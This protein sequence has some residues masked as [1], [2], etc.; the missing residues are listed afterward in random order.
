MIHFRAHH[1]GEKPSGMSGRATSFHNLRRG[2]GFDLR[3]FEEKIR[4]FR[5]QTEKQ[6]KKIRRFQKIK[7]D[8]DGYVMYIRYNGEYP[9]DKTRGRKEAIPIAHI[10]MG[11]QSGYFS[12]PP[13][14]G[15][16]LRATWANYT[17][18]AT[19]PHKSGAGRP[20]TKKWPFEEKTLRE[21]RA[22]LRN[23]INRIYT[24]Y[25]N[26]DIQDL[27]TAL[28]DM[29]RRYTT[30]LRHMIAGMRSPSLAPATI[31]RRESMQKA[32]ASLAM[33]TTKPLVESGRMMHAVE[34]RVMKRSKFTSAVENGEI[35]LIPWETYTAGYVRSEPEEGISVAEFLRMSGGI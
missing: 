6:K 10:A 26:G 32:G 17:K 9:A 1:H 3:K 14:R 29:A 8:K 13:L 35:D 33:G 25:L 12:G 28:R 16:N 34:A 23:N 24:K 20:R 7:N 2:K 15:S 4:Q 31:S 21:N 27:Y 30:K 18:R 5:K 19:I 11:L 22:W